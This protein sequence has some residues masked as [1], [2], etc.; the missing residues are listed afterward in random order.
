[1][2]IFYDIEYLCLLNDVKQL[3]II[4]EDGY[5]IFVPHLQMQ[6]YSVDLKEKIRTCKDTNLV[7][8]LDC[9]EFP[10]FLNK[11]ELN[12][13]VFGKGFL[14][15]LHCCKIKNLALV[16]DNTRRSQIALCSKLK[17]KTIS[18]EEFNKEVIKNEQYYNFLMS[19][20]DKLIV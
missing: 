17:I 11:N 18:I 20:K 14:F 9:V 2:F 10:S 4:I 5:K 1:M 12:D 13:S 16:I 6:G 8:M 3:P 15:L 19:N 7:E